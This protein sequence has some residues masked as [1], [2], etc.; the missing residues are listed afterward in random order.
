MCVIE[1]WVEFQFII[2][3]IPYTIIISVYLHTMLTKPRF[4]VI[5]VK[6]TH[7]GCSFWRPNSD[8]KYQ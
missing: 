3:Y 7:I 8:N 6:K 4:V 5:K 2:Y 1:D